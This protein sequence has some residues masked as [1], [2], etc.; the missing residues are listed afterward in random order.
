LSTVSG[1]PPRPQ[2]E[3]RKKV[4]C[5]VHVTKELTRVS[6]VPVN[7]GVT[8][9][10]VF[11]FGSVLFTRLVSAL[12]YSRVAKLPCKTAFFIAKRLTTAIGQGSRNHLFWT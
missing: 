3:L 1:L 2:K 11:L 9:Y 4:T 7:S 10:F 5:Q 8:Y 12:A 6:P